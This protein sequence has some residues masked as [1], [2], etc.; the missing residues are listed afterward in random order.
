MINEIKAGIQVVSDG[1]VAT[2]R[3]ERSGGLTTADVRGHYAEAAGRNTIFTLA[4]N[5]AAT[6]I[7]AG[8]IVGA[9]AGATTQ[10]ALW[11]PIG[12]GKNLELLRFGLGLTTTAAVPPAG[13]VFHG[14]FIGVPTLASSTGTA[15]SNLIGPAAPSVARWVASSAGVALTGGVAPVVHSASA[16]VFTAFAATVFQSPVGIETLDGAIILPPGSGW[17]PLWA[18][19]GTTVSVD[20]SITWQEVT[21]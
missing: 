3:A 1:T 15:Y 17:L 12:S 7:S 10:F 11:N 13:S 9:A 20:Y 6:P 16:F 4:I 8:N 21:P 19:A 2:A 18:A 14:I 5:N